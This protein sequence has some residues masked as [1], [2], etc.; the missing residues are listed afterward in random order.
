M[1]KVSKIS[2]ESLNKIQKFLTGCGEFWPL[3]YLLFSD[4]YI[5]P[6]FQNWGQNSSFPIFALLSISSLNNVTCD[7]V[8]IYLEL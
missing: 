4:W 2:S 5:Q 6:I 8:D 1:L 3:Y 7:K